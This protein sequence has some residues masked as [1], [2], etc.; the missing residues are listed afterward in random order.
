MEM[1][2]VLS[3]IFTIT[4]LL[5]IATYVAYPILIRMIG[6]LFPFTPRGAQE[7]PAVSIVIAAFNEEKDI[8]SKLQNTMDLE[9]PKEKM[10]ILVGS[11][12]SEDKTYEIASEFVQHGVR[13]LDYKKNRGKTAVQNDLVAISQHDIIV[14]TDAA[15]FLKKDS[16]IHLVRAFGD[17]RV[18]AVAGRMEFIDDDYNLTTESQSIYWKYEMKLRMAESSIG[19]LIGV[20]GPLY[21]V[22]K[23]FYVPLASNIISDLMTPLLVLKQGKRVVLDRDATVFEMPTKKAQQEIQTRR[24]I[25]LRGLIG[26][27]AF[28][29]LLSLVKYPIISFQILLHKVL[30]WFV[31]PMVIINLLI[32]LLLS[33][34]PFFCIFLF[35]HLAFYLAAIIGWFAEKKNI[36]IFLLKVPYYFCLV[37]LA[38]TL[39]I[40][41]FFRNKQA[42]S[43]KPVRS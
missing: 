36:S 26:I 23:E 30:R 13:V 27:F 31:G 8:E 15:S 19:R 2:S 5:S 18:G 35:L 43:W 42:V 32:C 20:D 29:E 38:A 25:T 14:F 39:G 37:N 34:Y 12:G 7:L 16:L 10:E 24:R 40:I 33:S 28:P 9:Y 3:T 4:I 41:D 1:T 21:A 22:R 6:L 17:E 11:D